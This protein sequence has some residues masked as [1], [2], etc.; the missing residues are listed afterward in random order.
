[1]KAEGSREALAEGSW[2]SAAPANP[3]GGQAA[4]VPW[5]A[6]GTLGTGGA[7]GSVAPCCSWSRLL[8][9]PGHIHQPSRQPQGSCAQPLPSPAGAVPAT[10]FLKQSG[11]NI[12]SKGFI[13]VNKVSWEQ[14]LPGAG[15]A[16]GSHLC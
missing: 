7:G 6:A 5:R 3:C 2:G 16:E 13:V 12:D 10:S 8:P 9:G 11:I 1:M 15:G 4:A 14:L